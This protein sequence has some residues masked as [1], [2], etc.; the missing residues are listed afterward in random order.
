MSQEKLP[1]GSACRAF[2]NIG[3]IVTVLLTLAVT[4]LSMTFF[5]SPD[6]HA[7][8]DFLMALQ[9]F[10]EYSSDI[11]TGFFQIITW[12]GTSY[13]TLPVLALVYFGFSS[14]LGSFMLQ[15]VGY[16]CMLN[17]FLKLTVCAM[18]PW[19]RDE[20]IIPPGDARVAATGYSFP[21]G[22]STNATAVSGSLALKV[23]PRCRWLGAGAVC[24]LLLVLFSRNYLGVHTPQDVIIGFASTLAIILIMCRIF[25][26]LET[27]DYRVRGR[28]KWLLFLISAVIGI[29][30]AVYFENKTYPEARDAA[31]NLVA[32]PAKLA[33]DSWQV[34]G[35]YLGVT[36]VMLFSHYFRGYQAENASLKH[37]VFMTLGAVL[38]MFFLHRA[39]PPVCADL[40]PDRLARALSSFA[41]IFGVFGIFPVLAAV[42][43]CGVSSAGDEASGES[44]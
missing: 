15:T 28:K 22:H 17:G 20:L 40:F 3:I 41:V 2:E 13:L 43:G 23:G 10:R 14:R 5:R 18:R 26:W 31:G 8:L 44:A 7:D 6:F 25:R 12:F 21:S 30:S 4:V 39:V 34:I 19:I 35:L 33:L 11:L 36:S 38:L 37:R 29:L 1:V 9:E 42:T 24:L 27:G 32:D 16:S